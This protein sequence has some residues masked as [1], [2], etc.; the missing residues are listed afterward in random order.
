MN[1]PIDKLAWLHIQD[2][3]LLCARSRGKAAFYLPGGKR[4]PGESDAEALARELREELSIEILP[5]TMVHVAE[6]A[7]QAD[8]MPPGTTVRLTCYRAEHRGQIT[9]AAE[10]EEVRWIGYEDRERCSPAGKLV[11]DWLKDRGMIA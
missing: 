8:G 9:P 3:R 2:A 5:E 6:F 7:A 1:Q 11:L 10:I 4:E